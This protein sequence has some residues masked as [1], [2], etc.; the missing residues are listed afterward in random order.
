VSDAAAAEPLVAD[1]HAF[2]PLA[3][4]GFD[5][6]A[7]AGADPSATISVGGSHTADA[8]DINPG[9]DAR[10]EYFE[11]ELAVVICAA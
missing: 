7:D 10:P 5:I 1:K 6:A 11:H 3:S 4:K 8:A 2:G 9:G